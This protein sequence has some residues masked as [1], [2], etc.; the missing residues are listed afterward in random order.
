MVLTCTHK[1]NTNFEK[2][3]LVKDTLVVH[4]EEAKVHDHHIAKLFQITQDKVGVLAE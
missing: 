1:Q 2:S 4:T 3:L